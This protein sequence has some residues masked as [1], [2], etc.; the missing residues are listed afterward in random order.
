M[1][2]NPQNILKHIVNQ[3]GKQIFDK[4]QSIKFEGLLSD[5]FTDD[6]AK[7]RLF[8]LA[9]SENI[10]HELL[11][12]DTFDQAG[13]TI[14]IN[15]L[16]SKFK[17]ENF[18]EEGIANEIVDCFAYALGWNIVVKKEIKTKPQPAP[19][20][21]PTPRSAPKPMP[22]PIPQPQPQPTDDDQYQSDQDSNKWIFKL[23]PIVILCIIV[24]AVVVNQFNSAKQKETN[25]APPAV[26]V[27]NYPSSNSEPKQQENS[28][29]EI[30]F[31]KSFYTEYLKA[32][33]DQSE[34]KYCSQE[35]LAA[36]NRLTNDG[37]DGYDGS[38]D[39]D[40]FLN[41]Q[42]WSSELTVKLQKSLSIKQDDKDNSWFIV[43]LWGDN[44]SN[45][46]KMKII[47]KDGRYWIDDIGF[48]GDSTIRTYKS[49]SSSGNSLASSS[50]DSNN[51][52]PIIQ[53]EEEILEP[54][55]FSPS[56]YFSEGLASANI[57][58]KYGV[59]D[60]TRTV[61]IPFIYDDLY[62]FSEGLAGV[63]KNGKWG[64]I[65]KTGKEII[66]CLYDKCSYFSEG[67]ASVKKGDKWGFIDKSGNEI[68][69]FEYGETNKPTQYK[70]IYFA[71]PYFSEGLASVKKNGKYGFIDKTGKEVI[72]CIYFL[73]RNFSDGLAL[74]C[75]GKNNYFIDK[76]GKEIIPIGSWGVTGN[77]S[78]GLASNINYGKCGFIDKIGKEIIP[79]IYE[80][81]FNPFYFSEGLAAVKKE[82]GK[83]G[84]ID[85]TGKEVIHFVFDRAGNFSE[86]LATVTKNGKCG[87]IDKTGK[88]V[89]P[90]I[91]DMAN[92]FSDGLASVSLDTNVSER[93]RK[94]IF[95]DKTGKEIFS[96]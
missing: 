36:I 11:Q 64:F 72:P 50:N 23:L 52:E 19:K 59:I 49:S 96:F 82:N 60:K 25:Q 30:N 68:T 20:P 87:F 14:K 27:P 33:K 8:R 21:Q 71:S 63:K 86:G 54:N 16:K 38:L 35:L 40:P 9:I 4:S 61:V 7:L 94:W 29:N 62:D 45:P 57:K 58:G 32:G 65:D 81:D 10:T 70:N 13:K 76:T 78:E 39:W 47:S 85:K 67:F 77:F 66:P 90:C 89:I 6:K 74:V 28:G 17:S 22:K 18:L 73:A 79:Y 41:A 34:R 46:I 75:T 44:D 5:Y 84:F 31:I 92:D 48:V 80:Y 93:N 56:F 55:S 53:K 69:K 83:W 43:K 88:E 2:T 24:I 1:E 37:G 3:F 51:N 91:Y 26:V 15:T 12:A 42:D 95:I